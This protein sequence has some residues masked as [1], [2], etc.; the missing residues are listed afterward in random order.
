MIV[1]KKL[2]KMTKS[3]LI[4]I[5]KSIKIKYK[6]KDT[7]KELIKKLLEPFNHNYKMNFKWKPLKTTD[8][9][10]HPGKIG[11]MM[12]KSIYN[13]WK[14][15]ERNKILEKRKKIFK[16][17]KTYFKCKKE[18]SIYNKYKNKRTVSDKVKKYLKNNMKN[19]I[20]NTTKIP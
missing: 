10:N 18:I 7:K 4:W 20:E 2:R 6:K 17:M 1:K 13:K 15:E 16:Q 19:C 11:E 14:I 8:M 5:C 9:D 3:D 12:Q